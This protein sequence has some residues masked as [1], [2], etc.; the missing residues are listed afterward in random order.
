M[1]SIL[2]LCRLI[3]FVCLSCFIILSVIDCF[4]M[5]FP[6]M[7]SP[8]GGLFLSIFRNCSY[9]IADWSEDSFLLH[10]YEDSVLFL[11]YFM[12]MKKDKILAYE[13]N[14]QKNK[15]RLLTKSNICSILAIT[16]S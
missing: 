15:K 13:M 11:S 5:L 10:F 2:C 1:W 7:V 6:S 16:V 8:F 3:G 12:D 9:R 4:V 14:G